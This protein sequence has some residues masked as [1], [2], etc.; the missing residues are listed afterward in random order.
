MDIA[1][2]IDAVVATG[3]CGLG[4]DVI[5]SLSPS[6]REGG[7]SGAVAWCQCEGGNGCD[8][9][10]DSLGVDGHSGVPVGLG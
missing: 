8:I 1:S 5:P 4:N 6:R 3:A 7:S 9:A 2:R 10:C